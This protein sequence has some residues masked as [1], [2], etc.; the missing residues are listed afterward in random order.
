MEL[1]P[2]TRTLPG[3]PAPRVSSS[4]TRVLYGADVAEE[5]VPPLADLV[6]ALMGLAAGRC[7]KA[8]LPLVGA[9]LEVAVVR[10][11]DDALVSLYET[12]P[13]PDILV[14]DRPVPLRTLLDAC[15]EQLREDALRRGSSTASQ[16]LTRL[17]DRAQTTPISR[18]GSRPTRA[19][20]RSGG[21]ILEPP[22]D[23]PLSFGF[24]AQITPG[25]VVGSEGASRADVHAL[26]FP[27]EVWAWARGHRHVLA[28]GPIMPAIGRMVSAVHALVDAWDGGRRTN[29]RLVAGGFTIGVRL[30]EDVTLTLGQ[31]TSSVTLPALDV[32]QAALPILRLASD[33]I[34]AMIATDRSQ[35]RNLKV[36]SLREE[37]RSLRRQIRA[38]KRDDGFVNADADRLR[39]DAGRTVEDTP[40]AAQRRQAP[41]GTPSSAGRLRFAERWTA[42]MDGLDATSTFFCGDRMIVATPRRAV[43][44][45]RDDGAVLWVR[46][47]LGGRTFMAGQV[48]VRLSNEGEVELCEVSDGEAFAT[49]RI[50]SLSGVSCR[51]LF[52]GGGPVPPSVILPDGAGRIVAVDLRNGEHRFDYTA[53]GPLPLR[54]R[55]AGRLV[56]ATAGDNN[57][58]AI[59]AVSGEVLWR[60]SEGSRFCFAPAVAGDTVLAVSGDPRG[61][62]GALIGL[63]L[64]SGERRFRVELPAAPSAAPVAIGR[65]AV[66]A[67]GARQKGSIACVDVATGSLSWMIVDPGIGIGGASLGVDDALVINT[68]AGRVTAVDLDDGSTRWSQLLSDPVADDV[69]RRLEPVL[70][71]G[72]LFVP[73]ATV[74]IL[75]PSDG[76]P[77]GAALPCSLV[78]DLVRVD[79]RGWVYVAEESGHLSAFAP[80]P[81]L[82]L[83]R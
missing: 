69:P 40:N 14:L 41:S 23:V 70:R 30:S 13:V 22:E 52:V 21:A 76:T 75:R 34:R 15:A 59:D 74:H 17:A 44:V 32:A 57:L 43:A 56:L 25:R 55:R 9:P 1:E 77:L 68:P 53:K 46:E 33:V 62:V 10:K 78:P 39:A 8:L 5:E 72:A 28:R 37:V 35:A 71:G 38:R 47:G 64:F 80:V 24:R 6:G 73:A 16:V 58:D 65:R 4:L 42:E 54:I 79:E 63:D 45:S 18:L 2:F 48:L 82:T 12:G 11:R 50:S 60:C 27:G 26:L 20:E 61:R 81:H 49:T 66:I 31:G 83:V 67:I 3:T 7:D 19:V 29:V 51:T 36:R